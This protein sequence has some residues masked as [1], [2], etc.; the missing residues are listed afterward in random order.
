MESVHAG[1]L[2]LSANWNVNEKLA[3]R[4][5][6]NNIFDRDPPLIDNAIAG[7]GTPNTYP[8]YDLLGRHMFVG[9][10]ARF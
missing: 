6:I 9:L 5:G 10:T 2:D 7:T 3:V 8:T 1:Y 4:A